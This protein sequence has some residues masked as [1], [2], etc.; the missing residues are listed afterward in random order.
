M[1]RNFYLITLAIII[2]SIIFSCK[3]KSDSIDAFFLLLLQSPGSSSQDIITNESNTVGVNSPSTIPSPISIPSINNNITGTTYYV[4]SSQGNDS[5]SGLSQTPGAPDGPKQSL[6]AA[7][8]LIVEAQPGDGILLR[9]GDTWTGP[10]NQIYLDTGGGTSDQN[11]I[12]GAYGSGANP[13]LQLNSGSGAILAFRGSDAGVTPPQYIVFENLHLTTSG[14][15]GNRPFGISVSEA[16]RPNL[17]HHITFRSIEISGLTYGINITGNGPYHGFRFENMNVHDNFKIDPFETGHSAGAYISRSVGLIMNENTFH[18]NGRATSWFD[19]NIYLN[20]TTNA[21]LQ[22]NDFSGSLGGLKI[23]TGD[24]VIVKG[25]TFT[26]LGC[27]CVTV[28]SDTNYSMNN[29]LIEQNQCSNMTDGFTIR[30]QSGGSQS[31]NITV[32]N[33]ILHSNQEPPAGSPCTG[34]SGL[35]RVGGQFESIHNI[36]ILNNTIYNVTRP[37]MRAIAI[38]PSGTFSGARVQ[39]NIFHRNT[40]GYLYRGISEFGFMTGITID[41]NLYDCDGDCTGRYQISSNTYPTIAL[42]RE[43]YPE[44]SLNAVDASSLLTNPSAGDFSLSSGSP[45]INSGADLNGLVDDDIMNNARPSAG[46]WDIGAY[47]RLPD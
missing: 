33:N 42:F 34:E 5:W 19:W 43:V 15:P 10:S 29:V 1:H 46:G 7:R 9:R 17:P 20:S 12:V 23:R 44:H 14:E 31:S 26:D 37:F 32:R 36:S 39:N 6:T 22:E 35:I 28:G 18:N 38:E 3:T 30:G 2:I 45:A 21:L 4:S 24:G 40:P 25:N 41:N 13:I 11:V 47:E 8:N 27:V 16:I